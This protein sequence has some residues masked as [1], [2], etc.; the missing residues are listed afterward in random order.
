MPD[1][2]ASIFFLCFNAIVVIHKNS[3]LTISRIQYLVM[4]IL[5]GGS[6]RKVIY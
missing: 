5:R 1:A 3:G 2:G 6:L 4:G